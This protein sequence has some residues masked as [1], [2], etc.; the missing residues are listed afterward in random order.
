LGNCENFLGKR[1][2]LVFDAFIDSEPE[3]RE[4]R[5]G[6]KGE[7]N[8]MAGLRSFNHSTSKRVLDLLETG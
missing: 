5:M 2:E 1:E 3:E 4:R 7:P 8:D 6:V